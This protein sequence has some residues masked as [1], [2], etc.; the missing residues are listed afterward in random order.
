MPVVPEGAWRLTL[1]ENEDLLINTTTEVGEGNQK[2]IERQLS[3]VNRQVQATDWVDAKL[4]GFPR[5]L[6]DRG[7]R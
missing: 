7:D 2:V 6:A 4:L 5:S 3:I 1:I